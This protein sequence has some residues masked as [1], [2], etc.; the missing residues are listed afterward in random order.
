[1][2]L[3]TRIDR[4]ATWQRAEAEQFARTVED[5]LAARVWLQPTPDLATAAA[6]IA[7]WAAADPTLEPRLTAAYQ[8]LGQLDADGQVVPGSLAADLLATLNQSGSAP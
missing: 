1:M 5:R 6:L 4:L 8:V 2:S 7:E 3:S